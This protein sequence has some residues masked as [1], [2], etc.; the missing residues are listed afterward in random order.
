[1]NSDVAKLTDFHALDFN[2]S[3]GTRALMKHN[4]DICQ[5]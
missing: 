5:K 3:T 4:D 2:R 1:M